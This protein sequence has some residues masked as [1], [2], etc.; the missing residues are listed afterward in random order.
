MNYEF[1]L[2]QGLILIYSF[3]FVFA[4][5]YIGSVHADWPGIK[6][7]SYCISWPIWIFLYFIKKSPFL[8]WW[9]LK[10]IFTI[11]KMLFSEK[12]VLITVVGV[13]GA[14]GGIFL[15]FLIWLSGLFQ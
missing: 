9:I 11:I 13:L 2:Q 1:P 5:A 10:L 6:I 15:Y 3:G 12:L 14:I 8:L 7:A 4:L